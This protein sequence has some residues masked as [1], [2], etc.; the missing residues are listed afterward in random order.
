M[1]RRRSPQLIRVLEYG[2]VILPEELNTTLVRERLVR[3]AQRVGMPAFET[4][5]RNLYAKGVVGVVDIGNVIVELLP[6]THDFA[7]PDIG[8]A[9]LLDLLR[10]TSGGNTLTVSD[11][12]VESGGDP[13]LE[14]LLAWAARNVTENV[15]HGLPRRYVSR[16][17]VSNAVRGRINL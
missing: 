8:R 6:K 12:S 14:A 15:R 4:R 10:F 5:G 11:A 16:E 9:F 2:R 3:A 7:T 17:E 1:V 13:L